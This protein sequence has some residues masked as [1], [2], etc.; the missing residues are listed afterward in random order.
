MKRLQMI[1]ASVHKLDDDQ[2][3]ELSKRGDV[4]ILA[5]V[6]PDL[7]NRMIDS[8]DNRDEVFDLAHN[9][10]TELQEEFKGERIMLVQPSGSLLFQ[11]ALGQVIAEKRISNRMDDEKEIGNIEYKPDPFLGVLYS[12]SKRISEDIPQKDGTTKKVFIFRH[13][14]FI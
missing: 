5:D 4:I 3:Y 13:E 9:C 1:W 10:F 12:Y 14:K 2:H 8:P 7:Q 6:M 11:F